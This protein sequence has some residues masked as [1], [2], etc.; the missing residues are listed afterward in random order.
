MPIRVAL[1]LSLPLFR[2]ALEALLSLEDDLE[3]VPVERDVLEGVRRTVWDVLV[4][5]LHLEG[6]DAL[7]LVRRLKARHPERGVLLLS[8]E[9]EE[10]S[11]VRSI[12]AGADGYLAASSSGPDL[13]AALRAVAAGR[14]YL[15][16]RL[17]ECLTRA[18][19]QDT[20]G[21]DQLSDRE[22]EVL[23]S[24]T[25]GRLV[26]EVAA[27][28]RLSPKTVSTYRTRVLRKLGCANTAQLIEYGIR[29]GVLRPCA[30]GW[31]EGRGAV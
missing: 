20:A 2:D 25:S 18:L 10:V 29:H 21:L 7:D 30:W 26:K 27:D 15:S 23:R 31:D 13:V 1:A 8:F 28:L 24:I 3:V 17:A 16:Q 9:P 19:Q 4:L 12:K 11:G 14:K 22:F 6:F 5:D